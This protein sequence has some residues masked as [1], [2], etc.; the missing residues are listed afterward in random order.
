VKLNG[1]GGGYIY[2]GGN[3]LKSVRVS[4][5]QTLCSLNITCLILLLFC[6][7]FLFL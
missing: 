4:I 7:N 6:V 1:L 5:G 3:I 2:L